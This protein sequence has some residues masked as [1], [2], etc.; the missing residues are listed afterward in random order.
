MPTIPAMLTSLAAAGR[1]RPTMPSIAAARRRRGGWSSPTGGRCSPAASRRRGRRSRVSASPGRPPPAGTGRV[2]AAER[3]HGQRRWPRRAGCAHRAPARP[4][5]PRR[6]AGRQARGRPTTGVAARPTASSRPTGV[7]PIAARSLRLT[8]T[9]HQPAQSG[10]RSTMAGRIASHAATT[11]VP[12]TGA[13]SSPTNPHHRR[14][15]GP[16]EQ[17]GRAGPWSPPPALRSGRSASRIS[18]C[19]RPATVDRADRP[20]SRAGAKSA[21]FGCTVAS[22]RS[23]PAASARAQA[24]RTECGAD[25]RQQARAA[26]LTDQPA[27]AATSRRRSR[28]DRGQPDAADHRAVRRPGHEH[29]GAGVVVDVVAVACRGEQSLLVDEHLAAQSGAYA[30]RALGL[31]GGSTTNAGRR[32]ASTGRRAR[33]GVHRRDRHGDDRSGVSSTAATVQPP[34]SRQRRARAAGGASGAPGPRRASRPRQ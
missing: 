13:P 24:A 21:A 7:A 25:P 23:A 18:T 19:G 15:A 32:A 28:Q 30:A 26:A 14:A 3:G 5:P 4:R 9:P 27:A 8:S 22:K 17:L 20:S 16:V 29:D 34:A 10:S 1:C 31:V 11:S 6:P 33:E 2:G 12:G